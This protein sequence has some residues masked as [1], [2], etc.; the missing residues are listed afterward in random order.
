MQLE[1]V[2]F[3]YGNVISLP[4][5]HEG[6]LEYSARLG[7]AEKEFLHAYRRE[8]HPFD[9]GAVGVWDYWKRVVSSVSTDSSKT[10][11]KQF[12]DLDMED[13]TQLN[14]PLLEWQRTLSAKGYRTGI[15]S[16][17]PFYFAE[18]YREHLDW[19]HCFDTVTFSCDVGSVKPEPEIY[20]ACLRSLGVDGKKALFLDD[21]PENVEGARSIGMHSELFYSVDATIPFVTEKYGI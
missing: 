11:L 18:Y 13:W 5:R 6:V 4:N 9:Q 12:I 3:D 19:L 2:I 1:A 16:N 7:I 10:I 15:L 20:Q 17:I 8:R 21:L 14:Q